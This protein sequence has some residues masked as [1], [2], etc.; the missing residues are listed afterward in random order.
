[1]RALSI[2][3]VLGLFCLLSAC[4]KK[5]TDEERLK[6]KID[7]FKVHVYVGAKATIAESGGDKKLEKLRETLIKI[8]TS[9]ET[10]DAAGAG[11]GEASG[12]G[13]EEGGGAGRGVP[14]PRRQIY[15]ELKDAASISSM[16]KLA[17]QVWLMRRR[18]ARLV[19]EGGDHPPVLPTLSADRVKIDVNT[20]HCV[21]M[22]ALVTAKFHPRAPV[23]VPDELILYEASRCE[24]G[25]VKSA[26][27]PLHAVRAYAF[28]RGKLCDL[29]SREADAS[30]AA[31]DHEGQLQAVMTFVSRKAV[32]RKQAKVLAAGLEGLSH[33]AITLCYIKRGE[34]DRAREPLGK[35]LDAAEKAGVRTAEVAF[36]RAY[37]DCSGSKKGGKRGIARLDR[38][39]K[40]EDLPGYLRGDIKPLREYCETSA[41]SS[42]KLLRKIAFSRMA[43]RVVMQHAEEAKVTEHLD[44]NKSFRVIRRLGAASDALGKVKTGKGLKDKAKGLLDRVRE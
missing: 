38:L 29:A 15:E 27:A 41:G 22:A 3:C 1:M 39:E 14:S 30:F 19:R 24:P 7:T 10:K 20:E 31:P 40:R 13:A 4:K 16:T 42:S 5:E 34:R 6:K 36:L 32:S 28:A 23:P 35:M 12:R 18:G 2:A 44:Q 21:L 25:R 17:G 9:G 37:H 8:I 43:I 33:G 11:A 26:A